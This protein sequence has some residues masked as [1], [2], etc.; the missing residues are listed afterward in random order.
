MLLGGDPWPFFVARCAGAPVSSLSGGAPRWVRL[1]VFLWGF[2]FPGWFR[3]AAGAG[4]DLDHWGVGD[5]PTTGSWGRCPCGCVPLCGARSVRARVSSRVVLWLRLPIVSFPQPR[6]AGYSCPRRWGV[7]PSHG[8]GPATLVHGTVPPSRGLGPATPVHGTAD[9]ARA[10]SRSC[11]TGLVTPTLAIVSPSSFVRFVPGL[12]SALGLDGRN[13][14][15]L[16]RSV[17]D[18]GLR[19]HPVCGGVVWAGCVPPLS[20]VFRLGS[21]AAGWHPERWAWLQ[22][23]TGTHWLAVTRWRAW[24]LGGLVASCPVTSRGRACSACLL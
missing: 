6:R 14:L 23:G 2:R 5:G 12:C 20:A 24:P 22:L 7:P 1:P 11:C 16:Y 3:E 19:P 17:V 15:F 21:C 13:P 9:G 10:G 4:S 18:R 8:V